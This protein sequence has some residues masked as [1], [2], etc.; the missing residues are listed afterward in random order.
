MFAVLNLAVYLCELSGQWM[1]V[2]QAHRFRVGMPEN[3]PQPPI[4]TNIAP[5]ACAFELA[6]GV[7]ALWV[8][9]IVNQ[10]P[11]A[12]I[13]TASEHLLS[14]AYAV[15][16]GGVAALPM[17]ALF[18]LVNKLSIKPIASIR[19][20]LDNN[21][22]PLFTG[23]RLWELAAVALAAGVGEELLFRGL[24]QPLLASAFEPPVGVW[25]AFIATS[26]IFGLCHWLT[27]TYAVFAT[28]LGLYLGGL[29][30]WTDNLLAPITAHALYDLV[31]LIYLVQRLR[32][33]RARCAATHSPLPA[34]IDQEP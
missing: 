24:L 4:T 2:M 3:S 27:P 32:N 1:I 23:S 22:L 10:L 25:I 28:L 15:G 20:H 16:W 21:L 6:L 19:D 13:P 5:Y 8:G 33:R 14:N 26:V 31:A 34:Q 17:L 12:S 29:F 11:H 9:W 30:L 7:L 18:F